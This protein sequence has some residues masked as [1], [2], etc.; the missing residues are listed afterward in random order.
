MP[1]QQLDI[2]LH[3]MAIS[4]LPRVRTDLDPLLIIPS[5]NLLNNPRSA[6]PLQFEKV[7]VAGHQYY[8]FALDCAF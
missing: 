1:T 6:E 8:R 5:C 2:L 3:T 7:I 4:G